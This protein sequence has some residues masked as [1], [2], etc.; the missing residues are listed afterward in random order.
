MKQTGFKKQILEEPRGQI[1]SR[2]KR[3]DE[4]TQVHFKVLQ[5]GTIESEM[6]YP[7]EY[8]FAHL[9]PEHSYSAHKET[10]IILNHFSIP[11]KLKKIPPVTCIKR[12]IVKAVK[13]SHWTTILGVVLAVAVIAGT[14]YV[15]SKSKA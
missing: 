10:E 7:P 1:F 11:Y 2:T 4:F 13:P 12:K 15:A 9:N 8:M 3:I 14:V 6:E 5:D